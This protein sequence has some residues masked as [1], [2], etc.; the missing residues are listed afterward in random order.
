M[1]YVKKLEVPNF[2]IDDVK[3]FKS[4]D[5]YDVNDDNK[6]KRRNLR[7]YILE[8]EQN[9]LCIY[10]E[11][12]L[13]VT[14]SH[15]EHLKPKEAYKELTFDYNNLAV[16]CEGLCLKGDSTDTKKY[17]CGHKKNN[18]FDESKFLNPI[19]LE[20][21]SKYFIYKELKK[22][23][24]EIISSG[25]DNIKANYMINQLLYLNEGSTPKA[26]G[27]ALNSF[28]KALSKIKDKKERIEKFNTLLDKT[29]PFV[30]FIRFYFNK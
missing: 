16:S 21:I 3:N 14:N 24:F 25:K 19:A 30:S 5:D 12:F 10:C 26:R 28:R 13:E 29:F 11:C 2:F 22:D 6:K 15:I 9:N 4:W 23:Y 20:D 17:R 18:L 8:N 27:N 1:R 7:K